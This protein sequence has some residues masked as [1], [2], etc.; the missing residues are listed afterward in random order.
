MMMAGGQGNQY[1]DDVDPSVLRMLSLSRVRLYSFRAS[2]FVA[3]YGFWAIANQVLNYIR[4]HL[5]A[6]NRDWVRLHKLFHD[7]CAL[8]RP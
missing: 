3:E 6:P 4:L 8:H 7:L 2:V 1:E 5:R